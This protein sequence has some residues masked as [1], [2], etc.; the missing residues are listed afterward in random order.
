[1]GGYQHVPRQHCLYTFW[2]AA[3]QALYVGI[4]CVPLSRWKDHLRDRPTMCARVR[5]ITVRDLG[6]VTHIAAR[7]A[8][9]E[10]IDVLRPYLNRKKTRAQ[11]REAY[12]RRGIP[13]S[14]PPSTK[15]GV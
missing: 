12:R 15:R 4:S 11:R 2:D 14:L 3:D 9:E 1:V 10:A 8:E 7:E 13:P 5:R 6:I